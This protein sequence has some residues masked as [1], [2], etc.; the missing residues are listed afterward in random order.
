MLTLAGLAEL[1]LVLALITGWSPGVLVALALLV[2]AFLARHGDSLA[3]AP[4]F[5]AGLLLVA[6]FAQRSVQLRAMAS[7]ERGTVTSQAAYVLGVAALGAVAGAA[8]TIA[9]R[10]APSH[11]VGVTAVGALAV[12][13]AVAALSRLARRAAGS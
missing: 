1:S 13:V 11:A 5:G 2:P 10:Y 4:L 12:F 3:V 7:I 9:V 6:E 8:A